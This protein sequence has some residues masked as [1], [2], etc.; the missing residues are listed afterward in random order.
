MSK[1]VVDIMCAPK[2]KLWSRRKWYNTICYKHHPGF[3]SW[4]KQ[5]WS[6]TAYFTPSFWFDRKM[7]AQTSQKLP[8]GWLLIH[9]FLIPASKVY[10]LPVVIQ[11]RD[12]DCPGG[13]TRWS[14]LCLT[15]LFTS[16]HYTSAN[17][18]RV[19]SRTWP[20]LIRSR[21]NR[22]LISSCCGI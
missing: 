13:K 6:C 18:N 15:P 9:R 5:P 10:L 16:N 8:D 22:M 12:R 1:D 4:R 14:V 19:R 21:R 2:H 17:T 11:T 3:L 20:I 7:Y